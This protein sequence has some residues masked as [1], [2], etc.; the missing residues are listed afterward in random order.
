MY[1]YLLHIQIL[2]K[3]NL[4]LGGTRWWIRNIL[5]TPHL[6]STSKS[7]LA[8]LEYIKNKTKQNLMS[9]ETKKKSQ[10]DGGGRRCAHDTIKF[11]TT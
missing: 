1:V 11:H 5:S 10:Q 7:Q 6:M 8:R 9:K 4:L 2:F 3:R